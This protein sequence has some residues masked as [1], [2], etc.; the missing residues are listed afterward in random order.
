[1]ILDDWRNSSNWI[2]KIFLNVFQVQRNYVQFLLKIYS[3]I[4]HQL[5]LHTD[6]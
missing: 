2:T 1:M 6:K 3:Q 5:I 4:M